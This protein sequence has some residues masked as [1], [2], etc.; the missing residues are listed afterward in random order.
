M[1][2]NLVRFQQQAFS[3]NSIWASAELHK[4]EYG[5]YQHVTLIPGIGIGP[6]ITSK[7]SLIQT[8]WLKCSEL[9]TSQSSSTLSETS[10]SRT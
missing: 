2:R 10:H 3:V 4:P 7:L 8:V 9:P 1:I 6:E 5:H